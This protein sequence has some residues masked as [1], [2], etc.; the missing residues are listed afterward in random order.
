VE[1]L[2]AGREVGEEEQEEDREMIEGDVDGLRSAAL[3]ESFVGK[4]LRMRPR[5]KL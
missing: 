3:G 2:R 1:T 5:S 4:T